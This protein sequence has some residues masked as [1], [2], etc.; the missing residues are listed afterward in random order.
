MEKDRLKQQMHFIHYIDQLKLIQR[1]TRLFGS[2]RYENDAEHSWHLSMM[3]LILAEH[4]NTSVDL[5][6]V[7]KMVLIHD[8]VEIE[9]GDIFL[10]D[11]TR[12]HDNTAE[13]AAAAERIFGQLPPDQAQALIALWQEFEAGETPEARYARS[14]DRLEPILQN[15]SNEGGAWME[16]GITSDQVRARNQKIENGSASLWQY[17]EQLIDSSVERGILKK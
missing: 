8:I 13:E 15:V 17:A 14:V 1:R 4:A 11:T 7:I 3:A 12:N 6:K 16:H 2:D 5:L 9:T 10:Y